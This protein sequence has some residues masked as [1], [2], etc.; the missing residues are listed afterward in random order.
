[1]SA[2][3]YVKWGGIILLV[4]GIV[5]LFAPGNRV[6]GL[7]SDMLE[8]WIHIVVGALFVYGG[9]R[10]TSAQAA[11]WSKLFGVIFLIIGVVGFLSPRVYGLFPS[12]LG[13]TD[14]VVHLLYGVLG[15]WAG[16]G[17]KT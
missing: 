12:G 5:G 1:M 13:A 17:S 15:A 2:K 3:S 8:D 9:L 14:N 6:A 10:G 4:L 16:F 11:S 7:N